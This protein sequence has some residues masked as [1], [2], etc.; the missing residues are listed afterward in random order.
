[1]RYRLLVLFPVV[2]A[3][4]FLLAGDL[5]A[6]RSGGVLTAEAEVAK[7]LA[8]AG[9]VV[10]ALA[11]D[12]RD[13]LR[14]AWMYSGLCYLLL[15]VRDV[16]SLAIPDS[17]A[18]LG[19]FAILA[20]L[21]SVAGTWMLAHAWRLAGIEDDDRA[22]TR[23]RLLFAAGALLAL[24]ITGLPLV[25]DLRTLFAGDLRAVVDVASDLGDTICLALVAPVLQTAL[26]MRGGV[27]RWPWGL[28]TA[29]GIAWIAYD[30][31]SSF[32]VQA[33]WPAVVE[34]V[35]ALACGLVLSAGIAQR[36][37]VAPDVRLS[38]PPE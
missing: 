8:L 12:R 18:V 17:S 16:V 23:G 30:A 35:R 10:A 21:A 38:I 5:T 7:S 26:A 36:M 13:Y 9:C 37:A 1:M 22:R 15:L 31:S 3:A 32:V 11:F 24:A 27:L 20:N 33:P 14:R 2:L 28:L 29:S 6:A 19:A 25:R 4:A 34:A